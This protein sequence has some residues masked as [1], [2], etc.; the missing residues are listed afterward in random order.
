MKQKYLLLS[1]ALLFFLFLFSFP[2]LALI[3]GDFGSAEGPTPDGCVDFEDL[4][5]FALAYG[6]I[7]ADDNWNS[8]CDIASQ[9]G[10]LQ[11]D[12]VIDFEDLMI[13]AMHYGESSVHNLTKGTYYNTIQAALDEADTD[14]II[15]VDDGTYNESITFPTDKLVTL[16]SASGIRDNVIIQ[17]ANNL[18]TVTIHNSSTGTTLSG[19]TITHTVGDTGRG[20]NK[21]SGNLIVD[22]C[23]ISGNNSADYG[24]GIRNYDGTLTITGSTISGNTTDYSGG[25]IDNYGTLTITSSTTIS[26]NT[27]DY[28]GGIYN[29]PYG[30]TLSITSSDISGNTAN[31]SGGGIYN[32][33]TLD[34][35]SSTIS[36][37]TANDSGGGI[38]IT[39][40]SGTSTITF[41]SSTISGNT[42][43][44]GGGIFNRSGGSIDITG[45]IISG[46]N[47]TGSGGGIYNYYGTLTITGSNISGNNV[48]Q[49]GGGIYLEGP[50][51]IIIGGS[52]SIDTSNFNTFTDNKKDGIISAEQHIRDSSGDCRSSYPNNYY[53][54]N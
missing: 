15:E 3:P 9:G 5:I 45:S 53:V 1:M 50:G 19:F 21:T 27:A 32:D 54:P 36:G 28:G 33:C 35:T 29:S 39:P 7:P 41:T 26:G 51:T 22:N 14:N 38:Y 44:S 12:S 31:D 37:N 8:V 42:A 49:Q 46:N 4:M 40:F 48:S 10:I 11:P 30:G 25:G 18:P 6:S 47:V 24:G 43:A 13:F 34:I 16:Q 52:S 20:I 2:S 17:G 23:A